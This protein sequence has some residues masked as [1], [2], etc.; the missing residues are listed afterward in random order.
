M[1]KLYRFTF[2]PLTDADVIEVLERIPKALRSQYVAEVIRFAK[3][4]L[5]DCTVDEKNQTKATGT[6]VQ[7]KTTEKEGQA[8]TNNSKLNLSKLMGGF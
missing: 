6:V 4:K 2:N 7:E 5:L 1:R 3:T 8:Q